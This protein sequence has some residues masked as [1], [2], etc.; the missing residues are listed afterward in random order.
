M[1]HQKIKLLQSL[2]ISFVGAFP[3]KPDLTKTLVGV[4]KLNLGYR[5]IQS[6]IELF[7]R[8]SHQLDH[9]IPRHLGRDFVAFLERDARWI[10]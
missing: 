2:A 8:H 4:H 5:V 1:I 7:P 3:N 10:Q 9:I 6:D